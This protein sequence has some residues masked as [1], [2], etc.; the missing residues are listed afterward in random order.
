MTANDRFK[1]SFR[2]WFWASMILATTLHFA[3][4]N[5]WPELTAQDFS[6]ETDELVV[7]DLP[8][9]VILPPQPEP[10]ARP[11]SPVASP[12][13]FDEEIT[14]SPTTFEENPVDRLPP[15]RDSNLSTSDP[16]GPKFTPF[17]V[18]PDIKN[19]GEVERALMREY[20]PVL[21]DA[22]IGGTVEVWFQIDEEGQVRKT[23]VKTSSGYAA[24]DG[25][26]LA[27][28]EIAEFTPALNRDKRVMVWISLPIT[29]TTR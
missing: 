29:F 17:T 7:V 18:R 6:V 16:K 14:I 1:R 26:A 28:A 23:Q 27:V 19:R 24:L 20:P 8:P 5:L 13:V 2:S 9:E 15:P 11:A 10:I 4:I 22:G 12:L 21:R 25:A 3:M